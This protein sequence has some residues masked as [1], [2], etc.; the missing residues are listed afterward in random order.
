MP[1]VDH[2]LQE[3]MTIPGAV[4]ASIV[5]YTTGF[6]VATTGAA[7]NEDHEAAAA[8]TAEVVQ[9][10]NSRSLFVSAIPH[11]LL[12]DLI[13]TTAGGYHLLRM[14]QTEFDS[15]LVLYVWLDR[16]RGN[17]AVARRMM[18]RLADE[19]VTAR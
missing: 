7:P 5:D 4:G 15:R 3:A 6:P 8:G 11:D 18:Q 13:I 12:E 1:G 16:I 9:A 19:L 17:L 14:V 2:C 10:A